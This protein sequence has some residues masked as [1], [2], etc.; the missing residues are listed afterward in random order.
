VRRIVTI[1]IPRSLALARPI[2]VR[3]F[4]HENRR[5]LLALEAYADTLA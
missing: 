2:V 4:A 1:E 5:T 3:A